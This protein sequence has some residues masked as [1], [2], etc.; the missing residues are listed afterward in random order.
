MVYK[1]EN[2]MKID[3][4]RENQ[5]ITY[6]VKRIPKDNTKKIVVLNKSTKRKE[7]ITREELKYFIRHKEEKIKKKS[8]I[9]IAIEILNRENRPIHIDKLI[10]LIFEEGYNLPRGGKTFKNTISTSL[11]NECSKENPQIKKVASAVYAIFD[12]DV[13]YEK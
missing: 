5:T 10:E 9:K 2:G 8:A 1:L 11:N 3:C 7:K 13:A 6:V 12:C 4:V